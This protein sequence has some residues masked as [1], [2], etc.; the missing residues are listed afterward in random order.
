MTEQK[1]DSVLD[2]T[3]EDH[4]RCF[5]TAK[6]PGNESNFNFTEILANF[7]FM[8]EW[9]IQNRPEKP[10]TETIRDELIDWS[11]MRWSYYQI[12]G[13]DMQFISAHP[14]LTPDL[15]LQY[16]DF[17]WDKHVL[18]RRFESEPESLARLA[19]LIPDDI[20]PM[21]DTVYNSIINFRVS[22]GIRIID[23]PDEK[24]DTV[25]IPKLLA[26]DFPTPSEF[27]SD[28]WD[29]LSFSPLVPWEFINANRRLPWN[30]FLVFRSPRFAPEFF[31]TDSGE[32]EAWDAKTISGYRRMTFGL[33]EYLERRKY[34][35]DWT[36]I[37]YCD[38]REERE[39]FFSEEKESFQKK[40][41][42]EHKQTQIVNLGLSYYEYGP[43]NTIT[44]YTDLATELVDKVIACN[45]NASRIICLS[46]GD[47][48]ILGS[49]TA[50]LPQN[51]HKRELFI[52]GAERKYG[53][54]PEESSSFSIN[55][56][57]EPE[58]I[59]D[60]LTLQPSI[61]VSEYPVSYW[62]IKEIFGAEI[63][64]DCVCVSLFK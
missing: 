20:L 58:L 43:L 32:Q 40:Y 14:R 62:D 11:W 3:W 31:M 45:P 36:T 54:Q 35:L 5:F 39:R 28:Q 9:V 24:A 17:P 59:N 48:V 64:K 41:E 52:L 49:I 18:K 38:F 50:W 57:R 19:S 25:Y 53:P 27:T 6:L 61:F 1:I 44:L 16:P 60:E 26:L 47:D 8:L 23:N 21:D 63:P 10:Y 46:C 37:S 2:Q 34:K 56:T 12:N 7:P 33:I 13:Y 29:Y 4:V 42:M 51:T 15:V 55:D 30:W 22:P